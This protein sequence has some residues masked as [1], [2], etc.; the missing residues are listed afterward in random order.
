[1]LGGDIKRLDFGIS[2]FVKS[3][4]LGYLGGEIAV[5][6]RM[7]PMCRIVIRRLGRDAA[8]IVRSPPK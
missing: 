1:M 5:A 2:L 7:R 6:A 3:T 4:G 8:A